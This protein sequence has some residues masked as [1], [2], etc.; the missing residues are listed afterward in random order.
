MVTK[1][2]WATMAEANNDTR[3][4]R[5]YCLEGELEPKWRD[6]GSELWRQQDNPLAR[7]GEGGMGEC[8]PN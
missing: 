7:R 1:W 8:S 4:I 5:R 3:P 2:S 6:I